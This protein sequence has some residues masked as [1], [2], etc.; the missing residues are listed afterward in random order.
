MRA[1]AHMP[2]CGLLHLPSCGENTDVSDWQEHPYEGFW[3]SEERALA[4][5]LDIGE[6]LLG[7]ESHGPPRTRPSHSSTPEESRRYKR[8]EQ[9]RQLQTRMDRQAEEDFH[10]AKSTLS[11]YKYTE[12]D[13][14]LAERFVRES[15]RRSQQVYTPDWVGYLL[16]SLPLAVLLLL[17]I[18]LA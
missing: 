11:V 1:S 7:Q 5:T 6:R 4:E 10:K 14:K 17:I 3:A 2:T 9:V 12:A 13:V 16:V 18:L 15:Q 8:T